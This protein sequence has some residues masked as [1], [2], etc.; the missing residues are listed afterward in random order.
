[1]ISIRPDIPIIICTGFSEK[2][3]QKKT[4]DFG[5]KGF[6]MK[7]IIKSEMAHMVRKVLDDAQEEP[8]F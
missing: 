8:R 7:P 1:L 6:L 3:S 2:I 5:I 4:K